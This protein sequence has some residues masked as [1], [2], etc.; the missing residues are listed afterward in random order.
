VKRVGR[1]RGEQWEENV[2]K[3]GGEGGERRGHGE[4][5]M[6]GSRCLTKQSF[7]CP[8]GAVSAPSSSSLTTRL[9]G[10]TVPWWREE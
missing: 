7:Q 2:G 1:Q 10:V 6:Q 4:A 8:P 5:R 3:N 9:W